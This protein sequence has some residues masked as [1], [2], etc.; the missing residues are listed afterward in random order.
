MTRFIKFEGLSSDL[1][2]YFSEITHC[3][4]NKQKD[5]FS[6]AVE[7]PGFNMNILL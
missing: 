5:A 4:P 3:E 6:P 1:L 7:I 2:G